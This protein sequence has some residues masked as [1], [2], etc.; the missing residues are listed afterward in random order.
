LNS[1]TLPSIGEAPGSV[2]NNAKQKQNKTPQ[3]QLSLLENN[4]V[5]S[6]TGKKMLKNIYLGMKE[7][8]LIE[9]K[10]SIKDVGD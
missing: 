6:S 7:V 5:F 9:N 8:K 3:S 10:I 2:S 1:R 4:W